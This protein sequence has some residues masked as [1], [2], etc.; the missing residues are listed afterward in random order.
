MISSPDSLRILLQ[1]SAKMLECPVSR[2]TEWGVSSK[3]KHRGIGLYNARRILDAYPQVQWDFQY[4]NSRFIQSL[5]IF[6]NR[7][8]DL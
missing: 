2:L 5:T 1:N 4:E 7:K 6:R 3:G 8:E